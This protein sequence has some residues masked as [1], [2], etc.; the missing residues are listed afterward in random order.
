[1]AVLKIKSFR[2]KERAEVAKEIDIWLAKQ[3]DKIVVERTEVEADVVHCMIALPGHIVDALRV[4]GCSLSTA[5]IV[6]AV[7]RAGLAPLPIVRLTEVKSATEFADLEFSDYGRD[8][9]FAS[10]WWIVPGL[11]LGA[12]FWGVAFVVWFML[13]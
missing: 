1:M 9:R 8:P 2:G 7:V 6:A 13:P 4:A 12:T 10:G 11:V 5:D 3:P